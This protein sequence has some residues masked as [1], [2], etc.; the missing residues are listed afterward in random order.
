[1]EVLFQRKKWSLDVEGKPSVS[2]TLRGSSSRSVSYRYTHPVTCDISTRLFTAALFVIA[3]D[4][5]PLP[6]GTGHTNYGTSMPWSTTQLSTQR[7]ELPLHWCEKAFQ[8][9][10]FGK[11]LGSFL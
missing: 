2:V 11:Q 7:S 8:T 9:V 6:W 1:M 10:H 3:K 4:W 5:K